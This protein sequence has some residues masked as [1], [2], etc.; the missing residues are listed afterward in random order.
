MLTVY[1]DF[2]SPASYLAFRPTRDLAARHGVSVD[3]RPFR[4]S[5][6]DVPSKTGDETIGETHRRVRAEA[7]RAIHTL[8]AAQQGIDLRFPDYVGETDIALGVLGMLEDDPAPFI[9]AAF[10]TYWQTHENLNDPEVVARLVAAHTD[11]KRF[12]A[13]DALTALADAQTAAE[14]TGVVDAPA[15][16][17]ADQIFIGR[18]HFPWI[19]EILTENS[20]NSS[21]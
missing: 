11:V 6:K 1:I 14:A 18:E 10:D 8:Y 17:V 21:S 2:K 15:Y 7:R 9:Q 19:E 5:E 13:R 20:L 12:D 16:L 4:T 3:W